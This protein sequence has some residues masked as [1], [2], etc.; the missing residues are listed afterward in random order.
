MPLAP[1]YR[2]TPG[3]PIY[4][5]IDYDRNEIVSLKDWPHAAKTLDTFPLRREF[6]ENIIHCYEP[7]SP[8]V[9][10]TIRSYILLFLST[11]HCR[12]DEAF[13]PGSTR[14]SAGSLS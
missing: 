5:R 12:R 10:L 7:V 11:S 4:Y 14:N 3:F 6:A 1:V 9:F 8:N 2:K 13:P